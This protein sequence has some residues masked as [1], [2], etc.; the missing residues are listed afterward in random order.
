MKTRIYFFGAVVRPLTPVSR[1]RQ[2]LPP[3]GDLLMAF[4]RLTLQ[5]AAQLSGYVA[6]TTPRAFVP[7]PELV[8][9]IGSSHL[10]AVH[11]AL[12]CATRR[13][14]HIPRRIEHAKH[15]CIARTHAGTAHEHVTPSTIAFRDGRK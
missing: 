13:F 5:E 12:M 14:K 7:D 15:T 11:S 4:T 1:S 9:F 3:G 8:D 10:R 6:S 2:V